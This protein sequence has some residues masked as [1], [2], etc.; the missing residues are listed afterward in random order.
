MNTSLE[1]QEY[2]T[3]CRE[4]WE[5]NK[6]YYVDSQPSISDEEFDALLRRLVQLEKTHP[7]WIKPDSPTQRVGEMLT[8]GFKTIVHTTPMLSLANTYS[9]EELE[10]FIKRVHRLVGSTKIPFSC[11]IKMDGVAISV[12][13]E[14]GVYVRGVTR[15]DGKKGDD[16]TANLKTIHALPL[17]LY[18]KEVPEILEVRG[19]AFMPHQTFASLNAQRAAKGDPL[20]A[21]PRNAAAGTLKLL[22]PYEVA[23]RQLGI[24]FYGVAEDSSQHLI[25]QQ[26]VHKFL[27]QKGL[28]TLQMHDTC[29]SMEEIW[30]FAE[31]VRQARARYP[32]D[33]DGIVIK[34]DDLRE[35]KNL[36]ATGKN[37]RWAVAYKFA[38][39]QAVTRILG[40]TVQ[41]GRTG[42]LTPVAELEP[43]LLA[44]STISRATLHNADEVQRKDIRVG[45][46]VTIEK[47]GD[48]IPK[49]VNVH[50]ALRPNESQP[51]SMPETCPNCGAIVVRSSGEV[52]V[53]CPNK[54]CGEQLQ[55]RMVYFAS[56]HGM[57]I[58][59][60]GERV[61]EQLIQLGLVSRP[62]DIYKLTETELSQ[63]ENFK[64]KSIQNLLEGIEKSKNVSLPRFLMAL[65]IQHVGAGISDLLSARAGDIAT[66]SKLTEEELLEIEGI[67]PKVA[68][69]VV[70]YFQDPHHQEE[71]HLLL[72][73]GVTPQKVE[74]QSRFSDTPFSGK[75]VVLTGSLQNYTRSAAA[76]LIK[77]RG[78]KVTESVSKNTDYVVAGEDPG[79]KLEKAYKLGVKV[80]TEA[81]FAELLSCSFP[82]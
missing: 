50:M 43:V 63:L 64:E 59:G 51:W 62:S 20:W 27:Q 67:G 26:Q 68:S 38:A 37:P 53:R 17:K 34:L 36:G 78:G 45:D 76:A 32:F 61:V 40:I 73:C 25:S 49:V 81:E 24:V 41:V 19:E 23:K 60:M 56:K 4:V 71:V 9:Q 58:E 54:H 8:G 5:H 47:G 48:V 80:L 28:P 22:D 14:N 42:I 35:Q 33:I 44:G 1:Y 75:T 10:E 52:A 6:R 82:R 29:T 15:G 69:A 2:E 57:D 30:A 21:N 11:E 3:L 18:G 79:S 39:E 72:S 74:M 77:E 46:M 12:R 31:K 7:E 55:R 13:Y 70:E 66:L 16:V 65:G